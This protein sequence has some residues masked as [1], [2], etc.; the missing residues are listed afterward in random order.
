VL[1]PTP[2][3]CCSR[4]G[5]W[6]SPPSRC[7]G[8]PARASST[9]CRRWPWRSSAWASIWCVLAAARVDRTAHAHG[10]RPSARSSRAPPRCDGAAISPEGGLPAR[11]AMRPLRCWRSWRCWPGKFAGLAWLD[12][13]IGLV[14]GGD[15]RVWSPRRCWL[16]RQD[17]GSNRR[18]MTRWRRSCAS[19]SRPMAMPAWPICTC[20]A[21][22][23]R[24][25]RP[26]HR[27]R[28]PAANRRRLRAR[29]APPARP[30]APVDR[31]STTARRPTHAEPSSG[32]RR[33]DCPRRQKWMPRIICPSRGFPAVSVGL[34]SFSALAAALSGNILRWCS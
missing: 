5:A 33:S 26:R 2:A 19:A 34:A 32:T 20:G 21:S 18:W 15:D 8:W 31:G 1:G 25:R 4:G 22:V 6:R 30:G 16:A 10:P 11:A 23:M 14:G 27:G 29:V 9:T 28:R 12:P 7:C 24:I 3:P 13:M 17:P